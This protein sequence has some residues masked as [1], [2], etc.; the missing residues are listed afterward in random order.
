[1]E[2]VVFTAP[3][4]AEGGVPPGARGKDSPEEGNCQGESNCRHP[5]GVLKVPILIQPGR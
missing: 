3:L 4:S 5:E 2:R 1:M